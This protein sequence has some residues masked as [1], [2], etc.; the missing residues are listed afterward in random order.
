MD[1]IST[2]ILI[3]D[4]DKKSVKRITDMMIVQKCRVSVVSD[5]NDGIKKMEHKK[6]ALVL[7][8]LT[9][10]LSECFNTIKEIRKID[11]YDQV[12]ILTMSSANFKNTLINSVEAGATSYV[13]TTTGD[14]GIEK[15]TQ[16][17]P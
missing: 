3:I 11:G 13:F 6:Y 15:I 4:S 12:P 1:D 14:K 10:P 17:L 2:H 8:S 16:Y 7:I 5:I 9:I